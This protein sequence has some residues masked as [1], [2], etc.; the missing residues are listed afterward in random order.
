M[1]LITIIILASFVSFGTLDTQAHDIK[2]CTKFKMFGKK[3]RKCDKI[4][5]TH[6]TDPLY[7]ALA[8][9]NKERGNYVKSHLGVNC[10]KNKK[11]PWGKDPSKWLETATGKC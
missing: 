2:N 8:S 4:D 3:T 6:I 9:G 5:H 11:S 1:K 7:D 10:V